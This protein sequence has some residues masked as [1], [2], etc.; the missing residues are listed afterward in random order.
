MEIYI[1]R[2]DSKRKTFSIYQRVTLPSGVTKNETISNLDLEAVN[3]KL[4]KQEISLTDAN[5]YAEGIKSRLLKRPPAI[6]HAQNNKILTDMLKTYFEQKPFLVSQDAA[7]HKYERAVRSLGELSLLTVTSQEAL[8]K[9]M[10]LET[11]EQQ[12][13]AGNKLN[14]IFK[15]LGRQVVVPIPPKEHNEVK[16]VTEA[17]IQALMAATEPVFRAAIALSFYGG[18]RA[19][20]LRALNKSTVQGQVINI[21][22]QVDPH[23][24][25]RLPKNRKRRKAFLHPKAVEHFAVWANRT[26]QFSH[27]QINKLFK[28]LAYTVLG[29]T[30]LT[31]HD[32]RHSYAIH[33]LG[34]SVP[35]QLVAQSMGNSIRV[36]EDYYS[37][38]VLSDL[39]IDTIS[40]M[41]TQQP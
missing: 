22:N 18:F 31:W 2:P 28:R 29:R 41:V 12:R 20:E 7:R 32:L 23:N 35:I 40:R 10:E 5:K 6:H 27:S 17:E 24:K 21:V 3:L 16:Y 33:L 15:R 25:V 13:E 38:F 1:R 11:N 30:D 39:G 8:T 36:C 19:G 26:E 4:L 34:S 14:S 9:I 37:G